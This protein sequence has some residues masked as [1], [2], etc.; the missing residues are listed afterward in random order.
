MKDKIEQE[1]IDN[2]D[3]SVNLINAIYFIGL[4][5]RENALETRVFY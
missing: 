2:V 1:I 4:K 5:H 3:L